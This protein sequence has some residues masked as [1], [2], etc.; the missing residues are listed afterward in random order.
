[1]VLKPVALGIKLAV[2]PMAL[3]GL[4]IFC[5]IIGVFTVKAKENASFAQ[6][7]KGLHKGV[8]VASA[9]IILGSFGLLWYILKDA[10]ELEGI[11]TWWAWGSRLF[12]V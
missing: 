3:A 7:L 1:M 8:Y 10:P 6:L 11:T 5:S 2:T 12:R 4:G 9:L